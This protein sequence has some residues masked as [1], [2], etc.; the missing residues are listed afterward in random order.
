MRAARVV[1]GLLVALSIV[2]A[3]D[4]A[5]AH[6]PAV[7]PLEIVYGALKVGVALTGSVGLW[8]I[9]RAPSTALAW[10]VAWAAIVVCLAGMAPV[11]FGR[12]PMLTGMLSI[13]G[14]GILLSGCLVWWRRTVRG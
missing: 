14:S 13:A 8:R 12:A 9:I 7:A 5:A 3:V 11:V 1:L 6:L 4:Q 2:N 10:L